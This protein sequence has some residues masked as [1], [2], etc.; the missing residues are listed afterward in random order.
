MYF[1]EQVTH[2]AEISSPRVV[3]KSCFNPLF[4]F[5]APSRAN[6]NISTILDN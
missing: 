1:D 6:T 5:T 3:T 2:L 4:P